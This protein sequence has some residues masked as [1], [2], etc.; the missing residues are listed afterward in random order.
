MPTPQSKR[1]HA[2]KLAMGCCLVCGTPMELP[3]A[4]LDDASGTSRDTPVGDMDDDT[5]EVILGCGVVCTNE[6]LTFSR[7]GD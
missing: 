5:V 1:V 6:C 2:W 3:G 4:K 7:I